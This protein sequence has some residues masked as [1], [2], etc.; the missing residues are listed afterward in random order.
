VNLSTPSENRDADYLG[1]I[2][3][4]IDLAEEFIGDLTVEQFA[5]DDLRLRAVVRCLEIISEASRRLSP[6]L[7][8]RHPDIRWPDIAAAGNF[9]RHDYDDLLPWRI[10]TTATTLVSLRRAVESELST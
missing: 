5:R 8:A 1:H 2:L 4:E 3:R 10:W 9:Y 7:K 6:E